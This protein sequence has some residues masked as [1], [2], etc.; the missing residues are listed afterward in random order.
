MLALV[1]GT[2]LAAFPALNADPPKAP[3]LNVD[4]SGISCSGIS[5]GA[6]FAVQFATAF[7]QNV[8][9][10][11]VFAGQPYHCAVT[12]F[13]LDKTFPC[14]ETKP[15]GHGPVGPAGCQ[16]DPFVLPTVPASP[17][18]EGLLWD[19]CKG[20]TPQSLAQL[21]EHPKLVNITVLEQ[22]AHA[23]ADS[24]LIDGVG[25]LSSMR[26]FIYRG[27]KD[28]CYTH[29]V[30]A[31]TS[32]WFAHFAH[33]ATAQVR[34][35]D[36]V[37][38]LHAIPTLRTGTPC[39]TEAHGNAVY[40]PGA[41]HGL[42]AC[43]FD[44]PGEALQH[45][46]GGSLTPP[47]NA[48]AIDTNR[49]VPFDQEAFGMFANNSR[50]MAFSRTG[51]IY[52]PERCAAGRAALGATP[53]RMHVFFHGCGSAFN[54][55]AAVGGGHGFN[56][57]FIAHAGFSAWGEANDIVMVFPQKDANMETCWDGYGW[58]GSDW[59]TRRGGQM[60]AVWR[61]VSHIAGGRV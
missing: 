11:G 36:D 6:D 46:Y 57:T 60:A 53:C 18:G 40:A 31:Q 43:G 51:F 28:A 32:G 12:R 5:S 48:S 52:V 8:M 55:G 22:Y 2:S 17:S 14:N 25:N 37:P 27:T 1:V 41:M 34:F 19:H 58:G 35:V 16:V 33:N 45:I 13:P 47:A 44:G 9:G 30:M 20:C 59:A 3:V 61:L 49:I 50:D 29:G 23:S 42:E 38:S 24:G 56:Y 39:G 21:I 10:V 26:A 4:P 7:S 54:S 15:A